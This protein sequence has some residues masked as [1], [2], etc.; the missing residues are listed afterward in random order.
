MTTRTRQQEAGAMGNASNA[1][2]QRSSSTARITVG[3][4][5]RCRDEL[6][7]L[8]DS[9]GDN[10]TDVVNRSI[11]MNFLVNRYLKDGYELVF[12]HPKNNDEKTI[13]ILS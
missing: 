10:Q 13:E 11:S 5:K 8:M 3:L 12:R 7:K 9:T 1:D 6:Q 2:G 4:T